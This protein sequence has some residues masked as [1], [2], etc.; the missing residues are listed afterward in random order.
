M[1]TVPARAGGISDPLTPSPKRSMSPIRRTALLALLAFVAP[2]SSPL[3]AQDGRAPRPGQ[4]VVLVTGSTSGLGRE[5]ALRM[6]LQGA[7]VIV[8]GRNRDR[9][10][11]VLAQI[12]Q[13]PGSARFYAA[14]FAS[15]EQVRGLAEAILADYDRLDVLVNNAGFGSAPDER[16]VSEDGHEFRFQVNYLAPYLLTDLLLPL[17][18]ASAPSRIVNVSS[19]AQS[20]IDWDDVMI[21]QDFSGRRAYGQSKLA[22]IS[23][24]FDLH[25]EL[26]GSGVLVNSLH[27]ATYMPTGMVRRAGVEPRATIDDG[28]DAVMHLIESDEIEGG[29]FFNQMTPQRAH[30]QAYDME[31]RRRLRELSRRLTGLDPR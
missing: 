11:E 23:H 15:F 8:H 24:T 17:V 26:A 16:W 27:P 2:L 18:R 5:V 7:H 31:S 1:A 22:Q 6:G 25:E 10:M 12:N 29:Q 9:G 19:L 30:E 28:A 4:Q 21:E 20:P 3:E 14:D 13:G